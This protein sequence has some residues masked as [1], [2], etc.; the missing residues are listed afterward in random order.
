M[1]SVKI[2]S[3]DGGE[4]LGYGEIARAICMHTFFHWQNYV[5]FPWACLSFCLGQKKR[6]INDKWRM[7]I[8]TICLNSLSH[9]LIC[10]FNHSNVGHQRC[11]T[12]THIYWQGTEDK[13]RDCAPCPPTVLNRRGK[14]Y[15]SNRHMHTHVHSH[16]SVVTFQPLSLRCGLRKKNANVLINLHNVPAKYV[17]E[18]WKQ[19]MWETWLSLLVKKTG[20]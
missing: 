4:N 5:S 3:C 12:H 18:L 16:L 7:R 9:V 8:P 1:G 19:C 15:R 14:G 20:C 11:L 6:M 13:E 2:S 10:V 17:S